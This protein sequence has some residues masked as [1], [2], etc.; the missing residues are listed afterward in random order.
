M[1]RQE[2][3][4]IQVGRAVAALAVVMAHVVNVTN[5]FG[6]NMPHPYAFGQAG[7]DFFFLISGFIIS[8]VVSKPQSAKVFLRNRVS[9]IFPLYW[10]FSILAYGFIV[11]G[12]KP[13]PTGSVII[14][15]IFAIPQGPMPVHG[16]GW[17]LEHEFIF[18]AVVTGLILL[19]REHNLL[20]VML[21]LTVIS[22]S[23]N[24]LLPN[25]GTKD[26]HLLSLYHL[27]FL[28][29]VVLYRIKDR[30]AV[31]NWPALFLTGLALFPISA[32]ILHALYVSS[33]PTQPYGLAGIARVVLFGV[34]SFLV[35]SSFLALEHQ[36]PALF[37]NKLFRLLHLVGAASFALYLSHTLV[38]AV[39]GKVLAAILPRMTPMVLIEAP[40]VV[41]ATLI[42]IA[43]YLTIEKFLTRL[44]KKSQPAGAQPA[45][46]SHSKI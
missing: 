30:V 44:L 23:T 2:Y 5:D 4:S 33:I 31:W 24:L 37:D 32:Y 20:R 35:L 6:D 41:M 45:R 12:N 39:L 38:F 43:I 25:L 28:L 36:R 15:S 40:A 42:G 8:S 27:Q 34:A 17:S 29:G 18:Y 26:A 1:Q 14:K 19:R 3:R 46:T 7:V 16:V 22:V 9:R 21:I 10:L 13:L 11:I